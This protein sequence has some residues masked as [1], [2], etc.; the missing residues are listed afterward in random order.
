MVY[1]YDFEFSFSAL[2]FTFGTAQA[3]VINFLFPTSVIDS[4]LFLYSQC[5]FLKFRS[6]TSLCWMTGNAFLLAFCG[7]HVLFPQWTPLP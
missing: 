5:N 4:T 6:L 1:I 7:A 2:S 3:S